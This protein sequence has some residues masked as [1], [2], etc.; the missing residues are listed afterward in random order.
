MQHTPGPWEVSNLQS[1][2]ITNQCQR[3][4]IAACHV[5][6]AVGDMKTA[7]AN[8]RLIAAAPELL[9]SLQEL[10]RLCHKG[11]ESSFIDLSEAEAAI[12]QAT[13]A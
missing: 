2:V 6:D 11:A 3:G 8:A 5:S 7:D 12:A 1:H 9:K 10:V 13:D 4:A